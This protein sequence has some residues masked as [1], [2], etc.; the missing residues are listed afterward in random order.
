MIKDLVI[1]QTHLIDRHKLIQPWLRTEGL[2]PERERLQSPQ[3]RASSVAFMNVSYVS[4]APAAARAIGG[5]AIEI[6]AQPFSCR[7]IVG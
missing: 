7:H 3:E 1:D 6:S 2:G 4:R 5:M